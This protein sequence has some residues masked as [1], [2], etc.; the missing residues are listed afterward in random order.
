MSQKVL[1][2]RSVHDSLPDL[3][4]DVIICY[5]GENMECWMVGAG[6][7]WEEGWCIKTD[8]EEDIGPFSVCA[9][10]DWPESP[11]V[12]IMRKVHYYGD[13]TE[14]KETVEDN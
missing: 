4:D 5:K 6:H 1:I 14:N 13:W 11:R 9:W 7:R 2:W 12:A 8:F 10:M 3:Y